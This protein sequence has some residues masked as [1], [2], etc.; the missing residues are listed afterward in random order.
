M[1]KLCR[2]NSRVNSISNL[3]LEGEDRPLYPLSV[4]GHGWSHLL[5]YGAGGG[6]MVHLI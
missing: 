1:T 2:V 4:G 6:R 5:L 3:L